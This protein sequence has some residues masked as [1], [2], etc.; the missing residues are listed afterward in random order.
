MDAI[1]AKVEQLIEKYKTNNPFK[2]AA[3][4]NIQVSFENL[5]NILGYYNKSCRVKFIHINESASDGE[6][7]FICFHEL[8]HAIFHP[9]ANTPFLEK[10]TFF[11][12]DRIELEANYFAVQMMFS[13]NHFDGQVT[14]EDAIEHYGVPRSLIE[15]NLTSKKI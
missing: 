10:R 4:L 13:K 1:I 5:G 2:I 8:A 6:K 9:D 12:N 3:Y 14:I 15:N 7:V 11:T